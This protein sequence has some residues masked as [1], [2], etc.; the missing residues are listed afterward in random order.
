MHSIRHN[1]ELDENTEALPAIAP[2]ELSTANLSASNLL[3]QLWLNPARSPQQ[4]VPEAQSRIWAA[5]QSAIY[6]SWKTAFHRY[7][8]QPRAGR[9]AELTLGIHVKHVVLTH[10]NRAWVSFILTDTGQTPSECSRP[11]LSEF[12]KIST[13]SLL[14]TSLS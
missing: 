13:L 3:R 10:H 11:P 6:D 1:H 5:G 8:K 7:L 12:I 14:T 2:F 9:M 4:I